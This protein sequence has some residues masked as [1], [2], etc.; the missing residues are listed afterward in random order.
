MIRLLTE[1]LE[2]CR[3]ALRQ[4]EREKRGTEL[5]GPIRKFRNKHVIPNMEQ[6]EEHFDEELTWRE[7]C[8]LL[9]LQ[10]NADGRTQQRQKQYLER[11]VKFTNNKEL[12]SRKRYIM[13]GFERDLLV[14]VDLINEDFENNEHMF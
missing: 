14:Y 1:A 2:I 7:I 12:G 8:D 9:G 5:T 11:F 3:D 13:T 6:L 4:I 10:Y